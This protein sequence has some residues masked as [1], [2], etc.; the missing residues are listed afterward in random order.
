MYKPQNLLI[1]YCTSVVAT[2]VVVIA[3]LVCVARGDSKTFDSSFST[4]LRTTRNLELDQLVGLLD[5]TAAKPLS[6]KHIAQTKL[7]L[8]DSRVAISDAENANDK[9]GAPPRPVFVVV[10]RSDAFVS[11]EP[12]VTERETRMADV[13][14]LLVTDEDSQ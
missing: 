8:L 13:D 7:R 2:A 3:S 11:Q 6:N 10:K 4:I 14:S 12:G 5:S 9:G 1:A